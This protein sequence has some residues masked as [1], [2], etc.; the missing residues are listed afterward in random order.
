M[1][2]KNQIEIEIQIEEELEV[3]ESEFKRDLERVILSDTQ[4]T[5]DS[6]TS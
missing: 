6:E 1:E 4:R 3:S 5:K 2:E